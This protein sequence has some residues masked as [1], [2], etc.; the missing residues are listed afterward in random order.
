MLP[1]FLVI[2]A[3]RCGTTS[4]C[5]LLG[6]HPDVFMSD[7]KE[8]RFFSHMN[9]EL[10]TRDWYESL[11]ANVTTESAVGEGSTGYTHPDVIAI[12]AERIRETIPAC[13]LI[14]MVR[15]P[16]T[17]LESDWRMRM[18]EGWTPA[19]IS[20]AALEQTSLVRHG[21]YWENLNVYRRFFPDDRILV[22]FLEDFVA[23][24]QSALAR[25]FTHIGVDATVAIDDAS[26]PRNRAADYRRDTLIASRIRQWRYFHRLKDAC[27]SGVVK[28]VERILTKEEQFV[29]D[30]QPAVRQRVI[31][32]MSGDATR[33]L[34][35]CGKPPAFWNL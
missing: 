17:R 9:D 32:E 22:V 8:P 2:G 23:D 34:S 24:P 4:I 6:S 1:N 20:E 3:A 7:P 16:I 31:D 28:V 29:P 26:R 27:P 30:W 11:F 25:C 21:L 12:T 18:H 35:H 13:R 19:S 5:D 10:R 14:Y 33:F 15:N